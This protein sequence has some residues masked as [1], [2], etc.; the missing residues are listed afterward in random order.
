[1]HLL[2]ASHGSTKVTRKTSNQT[3]NEPV[4]SVSS[5]S[6]ISNKSQSGI[7]PE[8]EGEILSL[9]QGAEQE[10]FP[11]QSIAYSDDGGDPKDYGSSKH[12]RKEKSR[13]K[14][15][16]RPARKSA[17]NFPRAK[18]NAT[19]HPN[20]T[21]EKHYKLRVKE[22][23]AE[24]N[25]YPYE[26]RISK[27]IRVE[28]HHANE[29]ERL[30]LYCITENDQNPRYLS[31]QRS[32]M[33]NES[34][35]LSYLYV[36]ELTNHSE[37]KKL[38]ID[39]RICNLIE[40][41]DLDK[42]S[43]TNE[44]YP[45]RMLNGSIESTAAGEI[46]IDSSTADKTASATSTEPVITHSDASVPSAF[47]SKPQMRKKVNLAQFDPS[48]L[49]Y[50]PNAV[51]IREAPPRDQRKQVASYRAPGQGTS[52]QV[53]RGHRILTSQ[54]VDK[55]REI[56]EY[57]K[58]LAN[59]NYAAYTNYSGTK[60]REIP[61]EFEVRRAAVSSDEDE[62]TDEQRKYHAEIFQ[63]AR[64]ARRNDSTTR[65][66]SGEIK[67][68]QREKSDGNAKSSITY[69]QNTW[70]R[71]LPKIQFSINSSPSKATGLS[72]YYIEKGRHSVTNLDR[73][74][75]LRHGDST[76]PDIEEFVA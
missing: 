14:I 44:Q 8:C 31:L 60:D 6:G 28:D 3:S 36:N 39:K 49:I 58:K 71:L 10:K 72:P 34:L 9:R 29:R 38:G 11:I 32:C 70:V 68:R 19:L 48:N 25:G 30:F 65:S 40:M 15:P 5:S 24:S 56:E 12:S 73:D 62:R 35:V 53:P 43:E 45:N 42:E 13:G 1:V 46:Q 16:E 33:L 41:L 69:K 57:E 23:I 55:L 21:D 17:S 59:D 26:E 76:D 75:I 54:D 4:I 74:N 52:H 63:G 51:E 7:Q 2:A 37:C 61:K 27:I 64:P 20:L 66:T 50:D 47:T 22:F 18:Q 67:K